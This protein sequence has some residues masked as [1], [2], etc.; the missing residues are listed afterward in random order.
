MAIFCINEI[1]VYGSNKPFGPFLR[2][3]ISY[4]YVAEI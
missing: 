1:A 3:Y 4:A 2:I